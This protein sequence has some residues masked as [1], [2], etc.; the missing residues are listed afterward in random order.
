MNLQYTIFGTRFTSKYQDAM[1]FHKLE[2]QKLHCKK[3]TTKSRG[4]C[5][6]MLSSKSLVC[7]A[8]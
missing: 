5:F 1:K 4:K 7:D 3:L 2:K 6:H 8:V